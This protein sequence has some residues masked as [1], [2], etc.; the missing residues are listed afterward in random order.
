MSTAVQPQPIPSVNWI[1][2]S[3]EK[4]TYWVFPFPTNFEAGHDGNYIF[5]KVVNNTWIPIYVGQGHLNVRCSDAT[6]CQCALARGATHIHAHKAPTEEQRLAEE[7][8]I[9]AVHPEAYAPVG[10]NQK[11]RG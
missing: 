2:A 7:R 3:G 4:Y 8:D 6:H 1:G 5:A 11:L 10:C 9:L